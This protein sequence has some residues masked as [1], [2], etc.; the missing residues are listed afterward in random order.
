MTD[1][2]SHQDWSCTYS[3]HILMSSLLGFGFRGSSDFRWR[4]KS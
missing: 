1:L 4:K 2:H 3:M